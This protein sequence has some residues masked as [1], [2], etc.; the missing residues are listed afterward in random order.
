MNVLGGNGRFVRRSLCIGVDFAQ[1]AGEKSPAVRENAPMRTGPR[2]E[3]GRDARMSVDGMKRD[4]AEPSLPLAQAKA[5][6]LL[7][8]PLA[9]AKRC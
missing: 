4:V 3:A 8:E 9:R 7:V 5:H 2:A 6:G 1:Q